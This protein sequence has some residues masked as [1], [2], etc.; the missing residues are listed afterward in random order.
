MS[1]FLSFFLESCMLIVGEIIRHSYVSVPKSSP[2][3]SVSKHQHLV[4]P[5]KKAADD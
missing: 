1:S 2:C 5:S 4:S 3:L